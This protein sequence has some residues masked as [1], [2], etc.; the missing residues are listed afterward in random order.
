LYFHS[1]KAYADKSNF[2]TQ[3]LKLSLR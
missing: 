1:L 3:I 2:A